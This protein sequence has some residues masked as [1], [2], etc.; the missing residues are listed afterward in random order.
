MMS[1]A[2]VFWCSYCEKDV[3][4]GHRAICT[5]PRIKRQNAESAEEVVINDMS[6][7]LPCPM[8]E[9][10]SIDVDIAG[11]AARVYCD[12]CGFL[13]T[14]LDGKAALENWNNL[15]CRKRIADLEYCCAKADQRIADLDRL[16]SQSHTKV[17]KLRKQLAEA[18]EKLIPK[19]I[20][21]PF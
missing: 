8:C 4:F 9:S 17:K 12:D 7:L 15:G 6:D 18:K 10:E 2:K 19:W 20:P 14:T 11:S 5:S 13:Y 3:V 21:K 1:N 16:F